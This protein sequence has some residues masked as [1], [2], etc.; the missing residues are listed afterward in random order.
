MISIY[1]FG[2]KMAVGSVLNAN[3]AVQPPKTPF[4]QVAET[5]VWLPKSLTSVVESG[6]LKTLL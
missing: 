5:Q 3:I 6:A 2:N 4:Y 1:S